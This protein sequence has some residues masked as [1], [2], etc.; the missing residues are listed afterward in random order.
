MKKLLF[1]FLFI[2]YIVGIM[3][4]DP[5]FSQYSYSPMLINPCFAGYINCDLRATANYRNQWAGFTT[6]YKL[7]M[8][9]VDAKFKT[10]MFTDDR[11][12]LGLGGYVYNQTAGDGNLSNFKTSL[13]VSYSL[14][15][16]RDNTTFLTGA[17]SFGF[18][19][20]SVDFSKLHFEDQYD[21]SGFSGQTSEPIIDESFNYYDVSAGMMFTFQLKDRYNQPTIQCNVG[22]SMDHLNTPKETFYQIDDN[23]KEQVLNFHGG[24]FGEVSENLLLNLEAW[25]RAPM[26][27][28]QENDIT[29]GAN[30]LYPFNDYFSI[31]GG[32]WYRWNK[33]I[34]PMAGFDISGWRLLLSYDIS[35]TNL[36][37]AGSLEISLSKTFCFNSGNIKCL[38]CPSFGSDVKMFQK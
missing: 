21:G 2:I 23:R 36:Q 3:A 9:S 5:S 24:A 1:I 31:Y 11:D 14:G 38:P 15:F 13:L 32:V 6:P 18:V 19:N 30:L 35:V 25:F 29:F 26:N 8:V 33:D 16:N 20:R 7:Q 28:F 4:Q 17:I 22:A 10:S 34:I 37:P 12:W 27:N